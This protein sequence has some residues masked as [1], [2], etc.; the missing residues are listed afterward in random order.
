MCYYPDL[1]ERFTEVAIKNSASSNYSVEYLSEMVARMLQDLKPTDRV[2]YV[3]KLEE[4]IDELQ[5]LKKLKVA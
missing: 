3:R 1:V 2:Y 4:S 5:E